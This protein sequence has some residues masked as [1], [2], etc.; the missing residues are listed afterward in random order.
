ME[1][2]QKFIARSNL[3]ALVLMVGVSYICNAGYLNGNTMKTISDKYHN[4]FT[5]AGFAFS[6]WGLIYAGLLGF[7]IFTVFNTDD[8][9]FKRDIL[10]KIN[11][12]FVVSCVM[13]SLWVVCWLSDYIALSLLVMVA[14]LFSLV[15]I[16]VNTRM[17]LDA[18]PLKHYL[19]VFWP[20]AIY[21][22]WISVALIANASAYLTK[23][24]WQGLGLS[25]VY[26]AIIMIAIAGLINI[27]M[28]TQRNLRE[29]AAVGVWALYA[30]SFSNQKLPDNSI[31]V[32]SCYVVMVII[33]LFILKSGWE[34]KGKSIKNM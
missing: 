30:I 13:N 4:Y 3:F 11:W 34:H 12:W 27:W 28:I 5:P 26:W 1:K 16:I 10:F 15:K 23:I 7:A 2:S 9:R 19:L 25:E 24:K 32:Y 17:E 6:I 20:F 33:A 14:L 8:N 31:I 21:S 18:H 29:F 22:G